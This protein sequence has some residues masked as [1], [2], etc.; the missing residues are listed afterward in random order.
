M[1]GSFLTE[2][3]AAMF[4]AAEFGVAATWTPAVG[5]SPTPATVIYNAPGASILQDLTSTEPSV[6]YPTATWPSMQ[7]RDTVVIGSTTY[8]VR[9][10]MPAADGA[11]ATAMLRRP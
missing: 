2:D 3:L 5:G 6:M 1:P 4:D 10:V 8:I 7:E 9:Q 11:V